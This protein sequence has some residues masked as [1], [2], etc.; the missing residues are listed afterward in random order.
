[1]PNDEK[2]GKMTEEKTTI[3][4]ELRA[5]RAVVTGTTGISMRPLLREGKTSVLIEPLERPLS[6]GELPIF[7]RPDGKYVIH[8]VLSSDEQYYYTRGDNCLNGEKV[9]KEWVLGVVTEIYRGKRTLR[10]TDRRYRLYVG[11]WRASAP[12][13]LALKKARVR[14]AQ[15]KRSVFGKSSRKQDEI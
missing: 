2:G 15:A 11:F 14:L 6:A 3:E 4:R 10:V 5:G 7:R 9:P 1:M 8:R 12:A 13:R